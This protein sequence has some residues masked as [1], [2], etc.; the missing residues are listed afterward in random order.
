MPSARTLAIVIR[1]VEVFESS[2]IVTVFTR[3]L[4][5]AAALA[6]GARRLKSPFE[7]G[8]D[9]LS[10]SD[11]VLLPRASEALDLL[12]ESAPVERFDT[13]RR[14]LAALY[15][16]FHIAQLLSDLTDVHDP[17]PRLFDAARVTL[18]RLGEG[19]LRIRRVARF[20]LFCLRELG[21]MPS[22]DTC[23][24]C[25]RAVVNEGDRVGF[26][27]ALGGIVC[28][29]CRPGLAQVSLLPRES[30]AAMRALASPGNDWRNLEEQG[31]ALGWARETIGHVLSHILGRRPRFRPLAG[32]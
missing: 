29:E 30:V 19:D 15:A 4:G 18:R 25:G 24:H 3:E 12:T 31:R 5:K 27:V 8:L 32:V 11:I 22:L 17:H 20:E 6:K 9:L 13:L 21:L 14:D 26:A 1:S 28:H 16:G 10:V 23:S 2:S 7:G